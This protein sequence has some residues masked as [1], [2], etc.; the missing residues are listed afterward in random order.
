LL[1]GWLAPAGSG[2][3]WLEFA[4]LARDAKA[5][6]SGH[7]DVSSAGHARLV[8]DGF[9]FRPEHLLA[10]R[11]VLPSQEARRP[12]VVELHLLDTT[13]ALR[14]WSSD[15]VPPV[16]GG[17]ADR[18]EGATR[19]PLVLGL[20]HRITVDEP[21]RYALVVIC[22][23]VALASLPLNVLGIRP[24]PPWPHLRVVTAPA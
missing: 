13:G 14:D 12:H 17:E 9:P 24:I 5:H 16:A 15:V 4:L 10:G 20:R 21:G 7:L 23:G 18:E 8:A 11:L 22:E 1:A 6:P 19:V 2:L 3:V